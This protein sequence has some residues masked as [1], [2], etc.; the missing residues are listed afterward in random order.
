MGFKTEGNELEELE[1]RLTERLDLILEERQELH[2]RLSEA[3]SKLT[4]AVDKLSVAEEKILRLGD[5][6]A[7]YHCA[8]QDSWGGSNSGQITYD[9][10]FYST[11][12]GD[13]TTGID[14][15]SWSMQNM[16]H[17]NENVQG[18]ELRKNGESIP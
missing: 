8:F 12:S 10:V 5:P 14:Q 11:T 6:P 16:D 2:H 13:L 4:E 7:A 15:I 3:E 9:N 18:L 1:Q 17:D